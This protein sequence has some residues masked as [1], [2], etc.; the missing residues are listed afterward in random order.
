MQGHIQPAAVVTRSPSHTQPPCGGEGSTP[1]SGQAATRRSRRQGCRATRAVRACA[2]RQ[3]RLRPGHRMHAPAAH[4]HVQTHI[5]QSVRHAQARPVC[6]CVCVCAC[7]CVGVCVCLSLCVSV[8][9]CVCVKPTTPFSPPASMYA[10]SGLHAAFTSASLHFTRPT[11]RHTLNARVSTVANLLHRV[12]TTNLRPDGC[13]YKDATG[14]PAK[15]AQL[16]I[17]RSRG[18]S[19]GGGGGG[20]GAAGIFCCPYHTL[21]A[22]AGCI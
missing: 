17:G 5:G 1:H 18:T 13:K 11:S 19:G 4:K 21:P 2:R 6:V 8:C 15:A 3:R 10:P 7:M 12:S 14:S 9:V 16:R 22:P 20:G